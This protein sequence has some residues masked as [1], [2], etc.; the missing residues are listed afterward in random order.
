MIKNY[1]FIAIR[2]IFKH[3]VFSFINL[4][5]LAI[6]IASTIL[7]LL[8]V[9]DELSFDKFHSKS[10][11]I[12]R[13]VQS[14][15]EEPSPSLPFPT[16]KALATDFPDMVETY[17]RFFNFQASTLAIEYINDNGS[18]SQFKEANIFF[19][20]STFLE[21]FDFK[22]LQGNPEDALNKPMSVLVTKSTAERY[23]GDEN[24]I[25]KIIKY[26]G[27]HDL[28]VTGVLEDTPSN[29]HFKFDIIISFSSI[30]T[31][32]GMTPARRNS[33]WFWNPCWTYI[34]LKEAISPNDLEN[35]FGDFVKK[36][37]PPSL[38]G[39][40]GLSLMP[41]TDIHLYS[42]FDGD[43]GVNS[44]INLIY[45][46]SVVAFLILA[47]ASINFIN[48]STARSIKRA[49]EVGVRKVIGA[50]KKQLVYQFLAESIAFILLAAAISIPFIDVSLPLLNSLAQK[51]ISFS[52]I[53]SGV[54]WSSLLLTLL[55]VG[56]LGGIY[57][58]VILSSLKPVKILSGRMDSEGAG[59]FL[60]R[61]LVITQF[62]ISG[63]LIIGSI[64]IYDQIEHLKDYDLGYNEEAVVVIPIQRSPVVSKYDLF[65]N[66]LEQHES[67][68][69]V[70]AS[71]T[72]LGT[73]IFSS[74]Y[75]FEGDNDGEL[76]NVQFIRNDFVKTTEIELIAG[77]EFSKNFAADTAIGG[78][79]VNESFLKY[80]SIKNPGEVI[81]KRIIGSLEGELNIIGAVKDFH[82]TSLHQPITPM[83]MI[84]SPV[85][86][87][88]TFNTNYVYVLADM[89][90]IS[91]VLNYTETK[92]KEIAPSR[93]F[94]YFFLDE[95]ID[96]L[97]SAEASL[98]NI[99]SI[100]SLMAIL[101][102]CLGL[103]GLTLFTTEQRTKEIGI[104][105]IV[106]ASVGKIVLLLSKQFLVLVLLA[107]LL[108]WPLSYY[109]MDLWLQDFTSRVEI[110]LMPFIAATVFTF[111]I[112]FLTMSYLAV[113]AALSNPIE[114]LK[115]E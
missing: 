44:D 108:A 92:F 76:L 32:S 90:K 31:V 110:N 17:V 10:E 24:P 53:S 73:E 36:Y 5:G 58:S 12:Y 104:R 66:Q 47:I 105:K 111:L 21:V 13:V 2:N 81:G 9:F 106:G 49:K 93:S 4:F 15:N 38:N 68:K 35:Q 67:I 62:T 51:E 80:F 114:A 103:F 63:L 71:N 26:E 64:I 72:I 34:V 70:S 28:F 56:M 19:T 48:L 98:G 42:K 79:I 86:R 54:F 45:I 27:R 74:N 23:F 77:R 50:Q 55:L 8:F 107:N 82:Y 83:L 7:I 22:L 37:Y 88:R 89:N 60:R 40:T 3:K 20:D 99:V 41:V 109:L 57:P 14:V 96:Q 75:T 85:E 43:I 65:K 52:F 6:G 95:K 29:S 1:F 113:K 101:I 25:G 18:K 33:N 30:N 94:D 97:Y 78:A 61:A 102:A 87:F 115:Y 84:M 91:D 16:A 59:S 39:I 46:F 11:R 69:S 112:A 100:F